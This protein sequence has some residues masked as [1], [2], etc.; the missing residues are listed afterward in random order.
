VTTVNAPQPWEADVSAGY[1]RMA[2]RFPRLAG[3]LLHIVDIS[4]AARDALTYEHPEQLRIILL[5][6][7]RH[8]ALEFGAVLEV[9]P[10]VVE[11]PLSHQ[12][13]GAVADAWIATD[14]LAIGYPETF[15]RL[16]EEAAPATVSRRTRR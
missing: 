8:D 4:E 10:V 5:A 2:E 11:T 1:D 3:A 9:V 7:S 16:V 14:L 6:A 12:V 15:A 13:R